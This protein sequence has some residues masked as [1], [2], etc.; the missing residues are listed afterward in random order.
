MES[1]ILGHK[2][3]IGLLDNAILKDKVAHAYIFSGPDGVGKKTVAVSFAKSLLGHPSITPPSVP[4]SSR[5]RESEAGHQ[6]EGK[7]FF[8]PDFLLIDEEA[9]IKIEKIRELIYKLS[10]KPYSSKYKVALIDHAENMTIEA[11]NALLK[12]LEEPKPNTVIVLT[13]QSPEHLPKTI[14]SRAQKINFGLLPDAELKS[15]V[16]GD[17]SES[18]KEM[19]TTVAAGRPGWVMK[20][21]E[22]KEY[23]DKLEGYNSFYSILKNSSQIDRLLMASDVASLETAEIKSVLS[24]WLVKLEH[25]LLRSGGGEIAHR[26]S[27]VARARKFIGQNFNSKLV[28]SDL[29]LRI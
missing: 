5:I 2:K 8:H 29:M 24:F 6:W 13:T 27:L 9:G 18:Q 25:D 15:L 12:S 26:L 4:P 3:Q 20:I 21:T 17:L 10:L 11:S 22:D 23:L 7:S 1:R 19:I 28:L 14:I 16:T